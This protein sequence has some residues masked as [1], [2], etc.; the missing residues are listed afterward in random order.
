M[1]GSDGTRTRDLR[2][3]RPG[4]ASGAARVSRG[5]PVIRPDISLRDP[6]LERAKLMLEVGGMEGVDVERS[7]VAGAVDQVHSLGVRDV[8]DVQPR[9]RAAPDHDVH[10]VLAPDAF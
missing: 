10:L 2:R 3:D 9:N 7:E 5:L 6:R 8:A 4:T 1:S